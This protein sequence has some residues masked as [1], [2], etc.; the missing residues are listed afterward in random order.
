MIHFATRRSY[1]SSSGSFTNNFA[2]VTRYVKLKPQDNGTLVGTTLPIEAW[3]SE[4]WQ[5]SASDDVVIYVHGFNT[6][7]FFGLGSVRRIER[8]LRAQGF[9]GVVIG[10]A[11]PSQGKLFNP[12]WPASGGLT[13]Y[14]KDRT[15]AK[16]SAPFLVQDVI[17]P[18]Q[19]AKP[20]GRIHLMAH[21]MGTYLTLRGFSEFGDSAGPLSGS[22]G[23]EQALFVA[24]D[25][26][27]DW[28][29]KGAWGG[30]TMDRRSVRL[31]NYHS[32]EDDVLDISWKLFNGLRERAGQHGVGSSG[33]KQTID[34]SGTKRYLKQYEKRERTTRKSHRWYFEEPGFLKDAA[35]TLTGK[36]ASAM[37]TREAGGEEGQRLKP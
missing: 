22:W 10:Y 8:G 30:M 32:M 29:S 37:P 5:R 15:M 34:V 19:K 2:E 18:L 33:S 26:D 6:P 36:A 16:K 35:I 9:R 23:I 3:A 11:W 13:T 27:R 31:T 12:S 17:W 21:S 1:N 20:N 24:A 14:R 25:A 4:V 28:M 7:F